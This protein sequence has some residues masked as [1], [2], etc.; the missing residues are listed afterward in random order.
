VAAALA[1]GLGLVATG[2]ASA[3]TST[4]ITNHITYSAPNTYTYTTTLLD[5][6]RVGGSPDP[7]VVTHTGGTVNANRVSLS[8]GIV[9]TK[10]G[11]SANF[12]DYMVIACY[13]AGAITSSLD[14]QGGDLTTP[15]IR[16]ACF[17][18]NRGTLTM[19]GGQLTS[20]LIVLSGPN[21]SQATVNLNGGTLISSS[22]V[23]DGNDAFQS[24]AR[25]LFNGGTLRAGS[26]DNANWLNLTNGYSY[27]NNVTVTAINAGGAVFDT[28]GR[29]M[30]IAI[31]LS[32]SGSLTKRGSGTLSFSANQNYAGS[33]QVEAGT[34]QL[35]SAN[36]LP[37]GSVFL[38]GGTLGFQTIT[39]ATLGG[40]GGHSDLAL[41]N[42][43]GSPVTLSVGGNGA[44]TTYT[45]GF[46]GS[47]TLL[48]QGSGSLTLGG[49][50]S[51]TGGTTVNAGTLNLAAFNNG[52]GTLGGALTINPGA[53]VVTSAVDALGW[54]A[55]ATVTSITVNGGT[56]DNTAAGN[57]GW[58]V[59]YT[60]NAA[61]LRTNGGVGS[62]S[63]ASKLSFGGPAGATTSVSVSGATPSTLAGHV[64]LRGDNGN[65]RVDISVASG[66]RLDVPAGISSNS[67]VGLRKLGAGTLALAFADNTYS[68]ATELTAGTLLVN[69]STGS[70]AVSVAAGATLGG[71]GE[72]RGATSIASGGRL[73]PGN[74]V[75]TLR[76]TNGL[77]L[78]NGSVLELGLG[79]SSDTLRVS[80]GTFTGSGAGGVT[81]HLANTGGFSVPGSYTLIDFTGAT[82]SGVDAG[83]FVLGTVLP[84]PYDYT[85]VLEGSAVKLQV[86]E[87]DLTGPAVTA[88][89][90]PVAGTR[91]KGQLLDVVVRFNEATLVT[92]T[93][94]LPITLASGNVAAAY[95]SG[96]GST[97]LTFRYSVVSGDNDADGIG[98]A[99]PLLNNGGS[100]RDAAGNA[101]SLAL[102][103]IADM[104]QVRVDALAP[105]VQSIQLDGAPG[106]G[107]TTVRFAIRFTEAV[108]GVD[109]A[110]FALAFP[111]GGAF[112][113]IDAFSGS[114]R[115]YLVDVADIRGRG[116]LR[117]DLDAQGTGIQDLV[118][119]PIGTGFTAGH[120]FAADVDVPCATSTAG[121]RAT[122]PAPPGPTPTPTCMTPCRATPAV[123][124]CGSPGASTAPA[125]MALCSPS[126]SPCMAVSPARKRAWASAAPR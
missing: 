69:G 97:A 62:T 114:G 126:R 78:A 81:V 27:L 117:L 18:G 80:G 67:N 61:T 74:P 99:G 49:F 25:L 109:I 71:A 46:T 34:L 36:S 111:T 54:L 103:G 63:A 53:T 26:T 7:I 110:D 125:P 40:L 19:S 73:A 31:P 101:A 68:G 124:R 89:D 30:G 8:N 2:G 91:R 13:S 98:I 41:Q 87:S 56:L 83:D 23:R 5:F 33:T 90:A 123:V 116:T 121:R 3:N 64:N 93:P 22:I 48:K 115:D 60:L 15:S 105:A 77:S 24:T 47:G 104:S 55:G 10:S 118:S 9:Y 45:G 86:E 43:E 6:I 88:V 59:A 100:L 58:G 106:A 44:N 76:F 65:T 4:D 79:S 50:S 37:S 12:S 16:L 21:S 29:S 20:N 52:A 94:Q 35:T 84:G 92:G 122:T 66:A 17:N 14:H 102:Q 113:R 96:S 42:T 112:G 120:A 119:N 107:S 95:H 108:T 11:G 51:H 38:N 32:G 57:N 72:V 85:I 82:P 1:F 39:A 28:N 70:G 75:G